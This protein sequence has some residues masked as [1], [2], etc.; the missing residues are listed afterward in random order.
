MEKV[1]RANYQINNILLSIIKEI[2]PQTLQSK[3]KIY[4]QVPDNPSKRSKEDIITDEE[5]IIIITPPPFKNREDY[6]GDTNEKT[7]GSN[8]YPSETDGCV[9]NLGEEYENE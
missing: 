3:G 5:K 8:N 6:I 1:Y 7:R 9:R 2:I 4:I